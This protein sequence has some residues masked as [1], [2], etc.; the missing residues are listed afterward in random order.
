MDMLGFNEKTSPY[1]EFS[2]FYKAPI[3]FYSISEHYYQSMKYNY[4]SDNDYNLEY[5]VIIVKQN[6]PNKAFILAKGKI[7]GNWTKMK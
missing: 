4:V 5:A 2:N 7:N 1:Y 3:D 6:T